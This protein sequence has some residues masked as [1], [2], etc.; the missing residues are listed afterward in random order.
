MAAGAFRKPSPRRDTEVT[1][2]L[3]SSST[4]MRLRAASWSVLANAGSRGSNAASIANVATAQAFLTV[5]LMV[6]F[7]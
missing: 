7:M 6:M 3:S 5:W 4:D 2:T 1:S